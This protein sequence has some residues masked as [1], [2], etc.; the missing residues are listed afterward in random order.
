LF[1]LEVDLPA[2]H[3][4]VGGV[5]GVVLV[6]FVSFTPSTGGLSARKWGLGRH[7]TFFRWSNLAGIPREKKSAQVSKFQTPSGVRV[8]LAVVDQ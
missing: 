1:E 5:W 8:N 6:S 3:P 2:G 7:K 4:H